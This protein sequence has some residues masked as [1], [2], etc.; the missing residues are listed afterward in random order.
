M[1]IDIQNLMNVR[2]VGGYYFDTFR[3]KVTTR[4]QLGIIPVLT[5]RLDF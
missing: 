5:W 3:N 4:Y 1:S 2:N